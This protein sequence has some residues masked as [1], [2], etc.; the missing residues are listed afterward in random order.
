VP[1]R[2][3]KEREP[4]VAVITRRGL[5]VFLTVAG[6]RSFAV[7]SRIGFAAFQLLGRHVLQRAQDRPLRGDAVICSGKL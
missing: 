7:D 4:N 2:L 3:G 5:N 6:H 1:A